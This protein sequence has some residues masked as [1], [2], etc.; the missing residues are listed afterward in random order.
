MNRKFVAFKVRDLGPKLGWHDGSALYKVS[1]PFEVRDRDGAIT[2]TKY[3]IAAYSPMASDHGLPETTLF[4]G[5]RDGHVYDDLPLDNGAE[6]RNSRIKRRNDPTAAFK[7][8]GYSICSSIEEVDA[9]LK[10]FREAIA[11]I[12]G[13][14]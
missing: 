3:V 6:I 12:R 5:Q 2:E 11:K 9:Q 4:F 1:P 14:T 8:H 13:K 7:K 10:L